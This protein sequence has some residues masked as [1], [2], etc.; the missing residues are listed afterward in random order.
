MCTLLGELVQGRK[1]LLFGVACCRRIEHLLSDRRSVAA[2]GAAEQYADG[3]IVPEQL[4][5][6]GAGAREAFVELAYLFDA[7]DDSDQA[8]RAA[9]A[10]LLLTADD[11]PERAFAVATH[12]QTAGDPPTSVASNLW[13]VHQE[14]AHCHILYE[15]FG[16]PF[17]PVAFA[18]EWRTDTVLALARQMYEARDFSA[19]PILADA[20]QDAG[21]DNEPVLG[22]CRERDAT[23]VRGCWV[24]DLVLGKE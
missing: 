10:P 23:H 20:L 13:A 7:R 22:H 1:G 16:N 15:I 18:P 19:M 5:A 4:Q 21:C 24:V 9:L 17:R 2:I 12:C 6:V 3:L 11:V 8:R 14:R